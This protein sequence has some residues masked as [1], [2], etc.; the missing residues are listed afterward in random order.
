MTTMTPTSPRLPSPPPAAEIPAGVS[1][2]SASDN[3]QSPEVALYLANAKRRIHPGTRAADMASGPP[4]ANL[5]ELDSAFQLQEHLAALHY[6]HTVSG[7]KPISRSAAAIL[8]SPPPS[9]DRTLW[10]YE[11][12]RFLVAQCNTLIVGF[13]FDTP[14][15]STVT[16]PE[17]RASE[18]QFLCAVHDA[19]KSC[20][21]IDYCCHT[22]DWAANV[23]TDP[24]VFPSRF[25]VLSEPHTKSLALKNLI[26]VF[27]RLHRIFAH[28]WFQ[29]RHV[30]W[31]VEQAS[32]LYV[33]FKMVCDLYNLLPGD[34]YKLP[35]EAEGLEPI[36]VTS[37]SLPV[38]ADPSSDGKAS[39]PVTIVKNIRLD[40]PPSSSQTDEPAPRS[41]S[42]AGMRHPGP[43]DNDDDY[44]NDYDA[45]ASVIHDDP[46]D[47]ASAQDDPDPAPTRSV[48]RI[49]VKSPS[50]D[51]SAQSPS[52]VP[53]IVKSV[54][55]D[56]RGPGAAS[57][58]L[59]DSFPLR[60]KSV[61]PKPGNMSIRPPPSKLPKKASPKPWQAKLRSASPA[62]AAG[63][64]DGVTPPP[65]HGASGGT[66]IGPG[67]GG[68]SANA[69]SSKSA[70]SLQDTVFAKM[71]DTKD[72]A[73]EV[74]DV[75]IMA[76]EEDDK[77][78][79]NQE[80]DK[81][82]T[83]EKEDVEQDLHDVKDGEEKDKAD[84]EK[85][86]DEQE[87][88]EAEEEQKERTEE[89]EETEQKE[90]SS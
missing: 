52:D 28:A 43:D 39:G 77:N 29:H 21:A 11:L 73:A 60:T 63:S 8:A 49:P 67:F 26:N 18:W 38:S 45:S 79:D 7:T 32:G 33:F 83:E 69:A 6:Y 59:G 55:P 10:L 85:S 15:C 44:D 46:E 36:S 14:P 47:D 41:D 86:V 37:S 48:S 90:E 12:C 74:A 70:A 20:C 68:S 61:S 66:V 40:L 81:P 31:D 72:E 3:G 23:V 2:P 4:L 71:E 75:T 64:G 54:S 27:R 50:P 5:A 34:T 13:L 51:P 16:C 82:K 78:K 42:R 1:M 87:S 53:V 56:A 35:P 65:M 17:M 25:I 57:P 84:E 19:P 22:L 62:A 24:K 76:E 88:R 89:M 9:V 30:F 58:S 80:D